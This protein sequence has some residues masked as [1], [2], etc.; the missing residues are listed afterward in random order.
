[1]EIVVCW[2]ASYQYAGHGHLLGLTIIV[3]IWTQEADQLITSEISTFATSIT[4]HGYDSRYTVHTLL[5]IAEK[6]AVS[7]TLL[8]PINVWDS[9]HPWDVNIYNF[10]QE[11][12]ACCRF[13]RTFHAVLSFPQT[14]PPPFWQACNTGGLLE[15]CA[16]LN[17]RLPQ[18]MSCP[19]RKCL[20]QVGGIT[21]CCC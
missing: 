11:Q 2:S 12:Q 8:A 13:T 14:T 1:M 6:H 9:L 20:A 5:Q 18:Q 7:I 15:S 10:S 17:T 3:S 4:Q 21:L 19:T 16:V